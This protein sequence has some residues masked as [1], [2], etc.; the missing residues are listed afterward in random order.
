[1]SKTRAKVEATRRRAASG[2]AGG[3][4]LRAH[5]RRACGPDPCTHVHGRRDL[6]R[7]EAEGAR[8]DGVAARTWR[9]PPRTCAGTCERPARACARP[10]ER[11]PVVCTAR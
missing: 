1:L 11:A 8:R 9:H 2:S 4:R 6:G 3:R 10:R 5:A 7:R